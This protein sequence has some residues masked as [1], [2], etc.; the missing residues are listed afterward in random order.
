MERGID[1][2]NEA[3][4]V[5]MGDGNRVGFGTGTGA[6]VRSAYREQVRRIAPPEL[7]GREEELAEP[8]EFCRTGGGWR[9]WRADAWA[10]KTAPMAWFTLDP[11]R[12][13]RIVPFFATARLG[14][15]NDVVAYVDV[16]LEQLA[17]LAGEGLPALL[18]AATREAHLLRLYASAAEACAA[19]AWSSSWTASTRTGA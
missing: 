16:V 10:G 17:E 6:E 15:Q 11:P 7:V 13:V 3:G 5:V 19:S 8:A 4:V 12:G 2:D 1:I 18:T 9:R 14:A